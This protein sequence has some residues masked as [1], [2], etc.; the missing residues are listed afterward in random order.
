MSVPVSPEK[1]M[2]ARL[3]AEARLKVFVSTLRTLEVEINQLEVLHTAILDNLAFLKRDR[4]TV[5]ASEYREIRNRLYA[6]KSRMSKI[7]I[8]RDNIVKV[9]REIETFI[10]KN[11]SE[12]STSVMGPNNILEFKAKNGRK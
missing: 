11:K 8:D 3:E 9:K 12:Y 4:V 1:L 6:V 2:E 7:K 5:M 10:A